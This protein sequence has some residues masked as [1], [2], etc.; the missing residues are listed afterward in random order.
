MAEMPKDP[1]PAEIEALEEANR[2]AGF[3]PGDAPVFRARPGEGA[4]LSRR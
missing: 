1:R 4:G 2:A 3:R